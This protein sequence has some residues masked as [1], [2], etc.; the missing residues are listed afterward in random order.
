MLSARG[1]IALSARLMFFTPVIFP[2]LSSRTFVRFLVHP[3]LLKDAL[4]GWF[5]FPPLSQLRRPGETS[6]V[7]LELSLLLFLLLLLLL[8][9][10]A[11][12]VCIYYGAKKIEAGTT[13]ST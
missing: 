13:M 8:S 6:K 4:H 2:S 9:S 12:N 5:T 10:L 3:F 7:H 11:L 1:S